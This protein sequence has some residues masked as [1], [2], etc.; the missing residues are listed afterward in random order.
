MREIMMKKNYTI[1]LAF[2]LGYL[3]YVVPAFAYPLDG[4]ET[5]GI[6][7]LKRLELI[8]DKKMAGP[9]LS[10]GSGH[11]LDAILLNADTATL[12]LSQKEVLVDADLTRKIKTLFDIKDPSYSVALLDMT[13]G[14][15]PRLALHQADR[16]FQVGSVGKLAIVVGLFS[17]LHRL[18]PDDIDKRRDLLRNRMVTA[19]PWIESDHHD[20]PIF[21]P[22]SGAFFS[23]PVKQGDEF[24]LYEW[25]DH[26][27]SASANS[28]AS[29][30]WK[31]LIL[32]RHFGTAYPP[33]AEEEELFFKTTPKKNIAE[34]AAAVVNEPLYII[35]ISREE[36]HLGSFFTAYGKKMIPGEGDS[37]ASPWGLLKYLV[38]MEQGK[39]VDE[40]SSLEIKR[41]MYT[42]TKRIRYIY[43]PA[44]AKA[45]VYFKSGSLYQCVPEPEFTCRKYMG[46]KTNIMNSVVIVEQP[47]HRV[48][49]V[50]LMTNV[51]KKNSADDHQALAAEIDRLILPAVTDPSGAPVSSLTRPDGGGQE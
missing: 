30:L 37:S 35:G 8:R 3:F 10:S 50:A 18:F 31:E 49:M 43:S 5:T 1:G 21:N 36:F 11:P 25:A 6:R 20:V 51:L 12:D 33:Q 29:T 24:S 45:A 47:D 27:I 15:A 40:W 7:R 46:N 41:L 34:L 38:A 17:E 14:R 44:L 26:M 16:R 22:D 2:F 13:P 4:Y 32:M 48:Y 23:R 28:A 42:T 19:G 39:I 9:V